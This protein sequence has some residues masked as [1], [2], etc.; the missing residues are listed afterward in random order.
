MSDLFEINRLAGMELANRF[1]RSATWEGMAD[2][3][4]AVTDQLIEYYA[5]LAKGGVGLIIASHAYVTIQGKA[6]LGQLGIYDDSL[7]PGYERLTKAVHENKGKVAAQ[8][9]HA[10][11]LA[12]T[13]LSGLPAVAPSATAQGYNRKVEALTVSD[14]ARLT[15]DFALAAQR[16]K[17]AGFDGV[18][19][20]AAHTYLLSQ[21]LSPFFNR[22]TDIYGGGIEQRARMLLEVYEAV[23][24]QVGEDYP[25]LVKIN[26]GDFLDGGLSEAHSL[27]AC[28]LLSQA[29]VDAIEMSGGNLLDPKFRP[30]RPGKITPQTE[31]YYRNQAK[32]VRAQI[33][34]PLILVGGIRSLDV[35]RQLFDEKTCDYI[36]LSRPLIREPDL[37]KRWQKGDTRPAECLSDN[38]CYKPIYA[39]KGVSCPH[40]EK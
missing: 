2:E 24:K 17:D 4:G 7:A 30:A 9:A 27:V 28:R 21:F 6:G 3:K 40:L 22:R 8:L 25:V 33:S 13:E 12:N 15:R 37:I 18:Q 34:C 31:A 5:R 16:A 14:I 32:A 39:G 38:L 26:S 36:S 29:G 19:I 23:R 11:F 20:H 1:V 35:A 10:G